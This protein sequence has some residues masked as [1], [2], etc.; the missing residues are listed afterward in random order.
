MNP[1]IAVEI[2]SEAEKVLKE[3][4]EIRKPEGKYAF[5]VEQC[6]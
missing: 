4:Y 3:S 6:L 5:S 1:G 2:T